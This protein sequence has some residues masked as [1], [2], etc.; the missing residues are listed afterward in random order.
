VLLVTQDFLASDF[1]SQ[2]EL[3]QLLQAAK[4][5]GVEILW[6]AVSANTVDD[7]EISNFQAVNN[8]TEPVD[9]LSAPEQKKEFLQIYKKIKQVIDG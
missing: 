9:G 4:S 2:Q 8:S 6:I 1:I 7:T 3:P 5:D